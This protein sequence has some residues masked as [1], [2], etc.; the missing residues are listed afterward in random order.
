[1]PRYLCAELGEAY[2]QQAVDLEEQGAGGVAQRRPTEVRACAAGVGGGC[3]GASDPGIAV[4][5]PDDAGHG[6]R[7]ADWLDPGDDCAEWAGAG[8]AA[9]LPAPG[10]GLMHRL[11]G[12]GDRPARTIA[13]V[14]VSMR[15]FATRW[16]SLRTSE[17]EAS[18]SIRRWQRYSASRSVCPCGVKD[19]L[20]APWWLGSDG[21]DELLRASLSEV[22]GVQGFVGGGRGSCQRGADLAGRGLRTGADLDDHGYVSR[23]LH[24]GI[25]PTTL[26]EIPLTKR[27]S[28]PLGRIALIIP[29][30]RVQAP[31][32]PQ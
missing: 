1:M 23:P 28:T 30:S 7:G 13:R 31:P 16:L 11:C 32:A 5:P 25:R 3:G 9:D 18:T 10:S 26:A 17:E 12:G 20:V 29:R 14:I 21:R 27:V 24:R 8:A 15:P 2:C 22:A 19:A 4:D 6:D